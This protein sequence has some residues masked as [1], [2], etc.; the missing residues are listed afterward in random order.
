[1]TQIYN[2]SKLELDEFC[3]L[4]VE[5]CVF[6]TSWED[7]IIPSNALRVFG[8]R[9]AAEVEQERILQRVASTNVGVQIR[10]ADDEEAMS[11]SHG[12]WRQATEYTSV[13]L[14]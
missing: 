5:N 9:A 7:P 13:R 2:P 10:Q 1:M 8:K 3:R 11:G 6:T 14:S 12:D 4:I